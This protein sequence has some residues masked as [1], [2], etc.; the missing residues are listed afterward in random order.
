MQGTNSKVSK[1]LKKDRKPG[2]ALRSSTNDRNADALQVQ[3]EAQLG[4]GFGSR[5]LDGSLLISHAKG[6]PYTPSVSS[7]LVDVTGF[8]MN[9]NFIDSFP[10]FAD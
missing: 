5:R 10:D 7:S 8:M 4:G 3:A 2:S 6:A 9:F 1:A